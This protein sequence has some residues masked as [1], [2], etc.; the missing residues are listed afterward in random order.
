VSR[1]YPGL[2]RVKVVYFLDDGGEAEAQTAATTY[3][4]CEIIVT[5]LA[6]GIPFEGHRV[7]STQIVPVMN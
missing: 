2:Y 6:A 7:K 1:L 3:E 4:D 5:G